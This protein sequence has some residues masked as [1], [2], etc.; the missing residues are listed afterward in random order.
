MLA[1]ESRRH[2]SRIE[3]GAIKS[4]DERW[5]DLVVD[6]NGQEGTA[7]SDTEGPSDAG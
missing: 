3:R 7:A 4:L 1:L 6:A 2:E 5:S